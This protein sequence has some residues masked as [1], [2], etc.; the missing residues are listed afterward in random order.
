MAIELRQFHQTFFDESVEGLA[1]MES[2]LLQLEHRE[3]G[4]GTDD[5]E[6][7]NAIFRV[8]HSIKGGT[9]TFGF[10]W[11][12]DFSHLLESLLDDLR[13]GRRTLDKPVTGLLLRGVDCLRNL[14]DA[15]R[16]TKT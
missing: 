14:L 3:P 16:G 12:T 5:R 2:M 8:V 6:T 11:L 4:A 7:L 15:A 13:E 1:S 10:G 9:G